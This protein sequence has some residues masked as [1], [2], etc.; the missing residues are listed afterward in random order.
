MVKKERKGGEEEMKGIKM[1]KEEGW[2]DDG[3]IKDRGVGK[4]RKVGEV[5][6]IK[7]QEAYNFYQRNIT[8]R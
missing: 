2:Q 4:K 5:P 7:N 8:D 1:V 6:K 3:R